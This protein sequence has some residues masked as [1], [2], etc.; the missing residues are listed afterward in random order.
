MFCEGRALNS[1]KNM[2][3]DR[4]KI[5]RPKELDII[6]LY[7]AKMSEE[8]V[9]P[10]TLKA[11]ESVAGQCKAVL[12]RLDVTTREV[13]NIADANVALKDITNTV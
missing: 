9:S 13:T 3:S 12:Q 1:F 4:S 8:K 2:I 11:L 6:A 7:L 5:Y 10:M